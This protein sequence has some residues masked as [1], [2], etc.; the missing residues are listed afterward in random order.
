MILH[1]WFNLSY[2]YIYIYIHM[3]SLFD[4]NSVQVHQILLFFSHY[5]II[6]YIFIP[7]VHNGLFD[8]AEKLLCQEY[9]TKIFIS[10]NGIYSFV[11]IQLHLILFNILCLVCFWT[12][13][14]CFRNAN[15]WRY[16]NLKLI[17]LFLF[18]FKSAL[19]KEISVPLYKKLPDGS[20]V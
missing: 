14:Y 3:C 17:W 18:Y 4:R 2:I 9:L 11:L 16:W 10:F 20:T 19:R 8:T 13:T 15:N 5:I 6:I 1:N 7:V 12:S